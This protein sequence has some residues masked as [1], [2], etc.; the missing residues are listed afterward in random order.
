MPGV[1]GEEDEGER[2]KG[3]EST[4]EKGSSCTSGDDSD[5]CDEG[6]RGDEVEEEVEEERE[7]REIVVVEVGKPEWDCESILR[8]PLELF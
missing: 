2:W 8:L 4:G 3:G 6:D 5:T 7:R 1:G